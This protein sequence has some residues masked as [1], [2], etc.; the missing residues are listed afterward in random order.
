[1]SLSPKHLSSKIPPQLAAPISG[2]GTFLVASARVSLAICSVSTSGWRLI[3]PAPG[4]LSSR[5]TI[6]QTTAT[7]FSGDYGIRQ[8]H[9]PEFSGV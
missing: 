7:A 3:S 5:H 4:P 2:L 1:M 9:G 6:E 8:K